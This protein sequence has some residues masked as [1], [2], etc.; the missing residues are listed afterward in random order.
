MLKV[1]IADDSNA[2]RLR[3]VEQVS[4]LNGISLVG[5]SGDGLTA[6]ADIEN[7]NPDVVILDIQLPG[8]GI[9]LLKQV[10]ASQHGLQVI[11]LTAFPYSQYRDKC[12]EAGADFFFDK[13]YEFNRITD[14]LL[15]LLA[16]QA[17]ALS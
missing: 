4:L 14:I 17:S 7:I 10:K 13:S 16:E 2:V 11:V 8:G 5:Q 12:L 6:I 3:L 1:Y 15:E 9:R